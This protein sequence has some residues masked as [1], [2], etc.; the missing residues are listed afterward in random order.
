M[1]QTVPGY[2]RLTVE[3]EKLGGQP[4]I[5]GYRFSVNQLLELFAAGMTFEEI[6]E[7]FPFLEPEDAQQ[8]FAY[9]AAL[10]QRDFYLPLQES[11]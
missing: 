10:A 5:R 3:S 7:D 2:D 8:V 1:T 6:H 9:A 4:C 11:A